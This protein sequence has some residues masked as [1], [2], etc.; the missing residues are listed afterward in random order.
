MSIERVMQAVQ[1]ASQWLYLGSGIL[2][3][4]WAGIQ[5]TTALTGFSP[6]IPYPDG[7]HEWSFVVYVFLKVVLGLKHLILTSPGSERWFASNISSDW[8]DQCPERADIAAWYAGRLGL[9]CPLRR[10]R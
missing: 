9:G 5:S 2:K 4:N 6:V 7:L 8:C 10:I 3:M 1:A